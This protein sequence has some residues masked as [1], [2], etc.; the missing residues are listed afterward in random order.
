MS[1]ISFRMANEAMTPL[2][3]RFRAVVDTM[4]RPFAA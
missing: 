4:Q 2:N 3:E 1:E